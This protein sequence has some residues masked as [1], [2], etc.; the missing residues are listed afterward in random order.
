MAMTRKRR[1]L[2]AALVAIGILFT[3]SL[4]Q[5]VDS[6]NLYACLL[7]HPSAITPARHAFTLVGKR[8]AFDRQLAMA[9]EKQ[10]EDS[11]RQLQQF[12][13]RERPSPRQGPQQL[14]PPRE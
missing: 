13:E 7:R 6:P 4:S 2:L 11:L 12:A 1:L 3:W 9:E 8:R 5:S 14:S 10:M